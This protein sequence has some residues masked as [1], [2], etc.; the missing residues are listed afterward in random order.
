M[1]VLQSRCVGSSTIFLFHERRG[2]IALL[3][4]SRHTPCRVRNTT[5]C[6]FAT[7]RRQLWHPSTSVGA[8]D[9]N[10]PNAAKK[11]PASFRT[12]AQAYAQLTW[13]HQTLPRK[14]KFPEPYVKTLREPTGL[15]KKTRNYHIRSHAHLRR[16]QKRSETTPDRSRVTTHERIYFA[17]AKPL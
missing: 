8:S 15:K 9:V 10:A 17:F 7:Y 16:K 14:N 5:V 2:S 3:R 4:T 12:Q 1:N 6:F 11:K 13:R